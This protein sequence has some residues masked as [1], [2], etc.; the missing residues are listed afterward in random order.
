MGDGGGEAGVFVGLREAHHAEKV[1][2][3]QVGEET[4]VDGG[5]LDER[6]GLGEMDGEGGLG[7]GDFGGEF[8]GAEVER[9]GVSEGVDASL[10]DDE[11]DVFESVGDGGM[12]S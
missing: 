10:D 1:F 9:V 3:L 12:R 4:G 7:D 8:G 2:A 6:A 5:E 11:P